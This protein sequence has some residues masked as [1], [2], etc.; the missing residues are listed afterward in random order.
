M[1]SDAQGFAHKHALNLQSFY[2]NDQLL[3]IKI[4]FAHTFHPELANGF[5]LTCLLFFC[6]DVTPSTIVC[7][8]P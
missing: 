6:G 4:M 8:C 2:M 3:H 5:D 1:P 7:L